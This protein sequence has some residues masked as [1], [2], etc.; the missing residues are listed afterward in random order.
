MTLETRIQR[1]TDLLKRFPVGSYLDLGTG[2]GTFAVAAK[3]LGWSV[4]AVDARSDRWPDDNRIHW[5][6]DDVRGYPLEEFDVI[7]CLG[8]FYH[9]TLQDQ[10]DLVS[11]IKSSVI[12]DTH[13]DV[14]GTPHLQDDRVNEHEYVGRWYTEPDTVESSWQNS[15][16][17]WHTKQSFE[18]LFCRFSLDWVEPWTQ[19]DR[20]FV[21][22]TL[23]EI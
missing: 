22:A 8:I 10:V 11:R 2:Q 4:T 21:L 1:F 15:K 5:V 6:K 9:L 20:T 7:G 18:R 13:F 17:F 16:S 3:D 14:D 23:E 12:I 19:P